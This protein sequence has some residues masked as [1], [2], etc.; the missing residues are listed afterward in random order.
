[1]SMLQENRQEWVALERNVIKAEFKVGEMMSSW[2]KQV[3]NIEQKENKKRKWSKEK[4]KEA[5]QAT[6]NEE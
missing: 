1:M 6:T 4:W 5:I 2:R 3:G